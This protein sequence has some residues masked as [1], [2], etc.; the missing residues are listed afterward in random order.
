MGGPGWRAAVL[1]AA[2]LGACGGGGGSEGDASDP[3]YQRYLADKRHCE[4]VSSLE[5][6]QK[7]CMTYR[8]WVDG[9]YRRR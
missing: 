9:K 1:A 2:L 8:G 5:A 3:N 4:S 6:A 7:S